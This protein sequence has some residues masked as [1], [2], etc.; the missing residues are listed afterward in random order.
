MATGLCKNSWLPPSRI[1]CNQFSHLLRESRKSHVKISNIL[2]NIIA[3]ESISEETQMPCWFRKI[4]GKTEICSLKN[5][6][7]F[8]A[9]P[10]SLIWWLCYR[11]DKS[12]ENCENDLS[13]KLTQKC[14]QKILSHTQSA[15][16]MLTIAAPFHSLR[17]TTHYRSLFPRFGKGPQGRDGGQPAQADHNPLQSSKNA[18]STVEMII[19]P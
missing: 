14:G 11:W 18:T 17:S 1:S 7:D 6:R 5:G 12:F 15:A 19:S 16:A 10:G 13:V 2:H 8:R 9:R 3:S 4:Q